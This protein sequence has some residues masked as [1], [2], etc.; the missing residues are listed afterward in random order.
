MDSFVALS[1]QVQEFDICQVAR[2][3]SVSRA[4]SSIWAANEREQPV[5]LTR[6]GI[7]SLSKRLLSLLDGLWVGAIAF[8][9]LPDYDYALHLIR[10]KKADD[11]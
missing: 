4:P 7:A 1:A 6:T 9:D 3:D 8:S 5:G 2:G 10:I 11:W